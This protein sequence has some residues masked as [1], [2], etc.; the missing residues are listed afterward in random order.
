MRAKLAR[1]GNS[2]GV[3]IPRPFIEDVGLKDDVE[4]TVEDGA[5]VIR[6]TRH[7]REGWTEAIIAAG[8][9]TAEELAE[10]E[11]W[12]PTQFDLEEWEWPQDDSNSIS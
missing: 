9:M 4:I 6:P 12:P 1:L 7:P 3:R 10:F 2:R 11:G 8:E 5:V